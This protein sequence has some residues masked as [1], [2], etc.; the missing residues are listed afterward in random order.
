MYVPLPS[1][2][3]DIEDQNYKKGAKV[4]YQKRA[5]SCSFNPFGWK[6]PSSCCQKDSLFLRPSTLSV[7]SINLIFQSF[8]PLWLTSAKWALNDSC[9]SLS[10]FLYYLEHI[11]HVNRYSTFSEEHFRSGSLINYV[12][13]AV[14]DLKLSVLTMCSQISHLD[15]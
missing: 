6:V 3:I 5:S 9:L 15:L 2:I 1:F 4:M 13:C 14:V 10:L 12:L 11:L 7:W 8:L